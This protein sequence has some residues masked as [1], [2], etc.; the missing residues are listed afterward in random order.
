MQISEDTLGFIEVVNEFTDGEL[1]KKNDLAIC[2]EVG[3][4]YGGIAE[5][6]SLIF[7][8]KVLWNLFSKIKKSTNEDQGIEL[9]RREFEDSLTRFKD[10]LSS[11]YDK[12]EGEDKQRFEDIYFQFTRGSVLNISDLAHDLAKVKDLQIIQK[13]K[14]KV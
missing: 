7:E 10:Y 6:N 11:I 12:L 5:L 1:R 8:G 2:F 13:T 4:T 9:L 3:A 14:N